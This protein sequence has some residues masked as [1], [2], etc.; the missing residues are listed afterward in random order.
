MSTY[1]LQGYDTFEGRP[2]RIAGEYAT[3]QEAHVA[4]Q[5]KLRDLEGSQPT[6]S[7]GGQYGGIQDRIYVQ[8]PD[9]STVRIWPAQKNPL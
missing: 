5:A 4:A 1:R 8:C 7:S 6:A 9:G 2:Y 3:L